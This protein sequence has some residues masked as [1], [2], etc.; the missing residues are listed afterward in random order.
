MSLFAK[1]LKYF[2]YFDVYS[3]SLAHVYITVP[4]TTHNIVFICEG[5]DFSSF[6]PPLDNNNAYRVE[7]NADGLYR[8]T[9]IYVVLAC[10]R[11]PFST[12]T[13]LYLFSY[14]A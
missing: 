10:D 7:R 9:R 1:F 6:G 4:Y 5:I 3:L 14:N 12:L 11:V 8:R 13:R 2:T